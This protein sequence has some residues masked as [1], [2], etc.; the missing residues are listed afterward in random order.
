M[1]N[2]GESE[3]ENCDYNDYFTGKTDMKCQDKLASGYFKTVILHEYKELISGIGKLDGE[4]KL[5]ESFWQLYVAQKSS[6]IIHLEGT[7]SFYLTICHCQLSF[8]KT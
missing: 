4:I 7:Q 8:S 1:S 3:V 2:N 5:G 6:I